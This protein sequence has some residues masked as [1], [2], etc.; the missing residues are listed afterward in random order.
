MES[1][2]EQAYEAAGGRKKVQQELGVTKGTLSDWKR[3]GYCPANRAA[4]LERISGISRRLLCPQFNWG[5]ET[6]PP[7][8]ET[9][10]GKERRKAVRRRAD[11][12]KGGA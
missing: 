11:K 2:I 9:R 7:E 8:Y 12:P 4:D 6:D 1:V 5:S 10:S 3:W